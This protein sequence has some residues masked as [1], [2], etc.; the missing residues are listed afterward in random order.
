MQRYH[1]LLARGKGTYNPIDASELADEEAADLSRRILQ[2]VRLEGWQIGKSRVFLRAGQLA[3][4]E[5]SPGSVC[6][7][8][9]LGSCKCCGGSCLGVCSCSCHGGCGQ[10]SCAT[11]SPS[12]A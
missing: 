4:M 8:R 12:C 10:Q 11:P 5:V 6:S 1:I 9:L 3:Q 7:T 2:A